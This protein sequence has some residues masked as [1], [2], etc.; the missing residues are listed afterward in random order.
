MLTVVFLAGVL[1]GVL[2]E[3]LDGAEDTEEEA[4]DEQ[5]VADEEETLP[6][7]PSVEKK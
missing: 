2:V 7:E 1:A 6:F 3:D 5:D 4:D